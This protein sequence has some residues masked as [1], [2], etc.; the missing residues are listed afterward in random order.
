[1]D[2][3]DALLFANLSVGCHFAS[4]NTSIVYW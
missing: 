2:L 1:M 3:L 4:I